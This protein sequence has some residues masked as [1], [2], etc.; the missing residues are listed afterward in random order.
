MICSFFEL[1]DRLLIYGH[2]T[3]KIW[4]IWTFWNFSFLFPMEQ[5]RFDKHIPSLFL[6]LHP[7]ILICPRR[8]CEANILKLLAVF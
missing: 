2:K 8:G 3:I 5:P 1:L 4:I 6:Y 7:D